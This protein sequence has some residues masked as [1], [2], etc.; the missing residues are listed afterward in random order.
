MSAYTLAELAQHLD[1]I[2]YGDPMQPIQ[3]VASLSLARPTDL[4][5][6]N[7]PAFLESLSKT[8][9]GGVLLTEISLQC[10]PV[11]A[12]VVSEP[13]SSMQAAAALF[14]PVEKPCTN[15]HSTALISAS[16]KLGKEVSVGENTVLGPGV[17]LGDRV[18]VGAN[19]VLEENVH[20]GEKTLIHH[21]VHI[22]T[23]SKIGAEVVI[24]SGAIIGAAPF[25]SVKEHGRWLSGRAVGGV[26]IADRVHLGA[27]TVITRGAM[28]DTLIA[29]G[30]HIDNLVMIAHD[31][32]IGANSAIAG[33]A[34]IGAYAQLGEHCIVGGAS[35]LAPY[36]HLAD[37]VV[38][39]GMSTVNKSLTKAGIYSSGTMVCEHRQWRRNAARFRR[40]DDYITRLIKLEKDESQVGSENI[41]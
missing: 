1:G 35:C 9:A 20:V 6:F 38:I 10:C 32:I 19:C 13:L 7:H 8:Q 28:G 22:H 40:L 26:L 27:N 18:S 2:V 41:I 21:A 24:E 29:H 5:C 31:V 34:V 30:V 33:C 25:N 4:S 36:V 37:D 3:G 39:T 16:A 17:I 14:M 15:I 11:N 12:I 23:S